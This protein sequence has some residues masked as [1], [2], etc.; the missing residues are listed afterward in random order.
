MQVRRVYEAP[1]PDDGRRILVDRLWPRGLTRE[2]AAIDHWAKDLAPSHG[3]RKAYH[4]GELDHAHFCAQYQAELAD[5]D[6]GPLAGDVTLVTAAK[7]VEL[8]HVPVLVHLMR[9][10]G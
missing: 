7:N 4:A 1:R 3:L 9:N 6:L 5:A 8:S 2:A 10:R